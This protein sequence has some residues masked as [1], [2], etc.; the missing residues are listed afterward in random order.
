[1]YDEL[2]LL[3]QAQSEAE[4]IADEIGFTNDVDRRKFVFLSLTA[5]A[6]TTFGFGSKAIA[7]GG[8]GGGGGGRGQGQATPPVP[9]DNMEAV[10]WTFQPYPGGTGVLLEKTYREK[11]VAA[12][13]RQPFAWT[14]AAG[15]FYIQPWGSAP[16]PSTDEEI[17]FLP[18]HRLAAAIKAG[19]LTST[20]LTKIY[21]ERL[22]KLNPTLL[23]AVTIMEEQGLAQAAAMDAELK[24]G[25][26]R[27]PL[28]GIPWGVKD[29]F[30][31]KGT[32][33]TWGAKDFENRV[34]D[35]DAEVVVRLRNAGAVLI[36]KLST[37][38]FAQ[39]AN[40]FRGQTKNPWNTW[41]QSSGS[42]AGP[43][44]ATAGGCVAF[45][46]GTETS[47]SIVSPTA[48]CG[49]SA[50]RPTFGRVSRYGG[51]VLA[52]SQD[53]VGP[54]TRT[55]EDA[56]MV[57]N[58][59]HGVDPKD[60]GTITMPF[61]FN[62]NINLANLRIGVRP[63]NEQN[64]D[65][66]FPA[67]VA[68]LK[69]LGAKPKD[70]GA[71]PTVAGSQGGLGAESAAAFD[72]YVQMKAKELGMDMATV[73]TTFGG[74]GGRGG[75]GGDGPGVTPA[76]RGAA[77]SSAAGG[78]GGRG[79]GPNDNGGQLNR[80]VP[81]RT[82]TAMDFINSQRRRQMLITAW[83]EYLKDIDLYIGAADTGIHAQTGHPVAVVQMAFGVRP[84]GGGGGRGGRGGGRGGDSTATAAPPAPPPP[85]NP[86]PICTQ[87]AGNLYNDDII[88]AVAHK[89]Q[90]NTKWHLER[91][92]LG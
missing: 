89:Y 58:V 34:I 69:E 84:A 90:I 26:Y 83:Q 74:R 73:V 8:G 66:N 55:A 35:E 33:T 17:A 76:G 31:V 9:L 47:G 27:G 41:Q 7:Q 32:P 60:P 22:K 64:P 77:D 14:P 53:R 49:L 6:A 23:C 2:D 37:G 25:K 44:S 16:L 38:Q 63:Q 82:P 36:A 40:W 5:A 28:H 24:A 19:K 48:Q 3:D 30:A 52:W 67:F 13:T 57:F 51:M 62:S 81:G 12:F 91:P 10:S 29:L 1:M 45:G 70:I 15:A 21:L 92:K 65:P 11:G 71:P 72:A 85:V 61:H 50:L 39:A 87:I 46:I 18:A 68:K 88:L 54:I 75:G 80:W 4:A 42:S 79:S 78:R 59:I 56:A 86:Q 20:R 43:A